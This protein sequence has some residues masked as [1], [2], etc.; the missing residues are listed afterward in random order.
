MRVI[1][2]VIDGLADR[3]AQA[4][5]GMTP[6]EAAATPNLD[7]IV[8]RGSG[9]LHSSLGPGV[10]PG[11]DTA[12]FVFLGNRLQDYPGRALFEAAGAGL[13]VAEGEVVL[14]GSFCHVERR[15]DALHLVNRQID[16]DAD[17]ACELV[18]GIAAHEAGGYR[19][20]LVH[21]VGKESILYVR[22]GSLSSAV[23]DSDPYADDAFV[24][25]V[26]AMADAED[27]AEAASTADAVT[28]YLRWAH[29]RLAAHPINTERIS[30][31]QAP[32]NFLATKWAATRR[33]IVQFSERFPFV[34]ASV[35]WG[36]LFRGLCAE[37][38]L[39]FRN[40]EYL[41]DPGND[42]ARRIDTALELL[43]A[44]R[45][46]FVHVHTKLVDHAAH[47]KDPQLKRQTIESCDAGLAR[48]AV[49]DDPETLIVVT[50]DHATASSGDSL[51]IH[52]GEPV[53]I[54]VV[55]RTVPV[56]EVTRFSE[57]TCRPGMLGTTTA[58][59][60]MPRILNWTDRTGY[61][62]ARMSP[63]SQIARPR[64]A[65]PFTVA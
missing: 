42:L 54:A 53:P 41:D 23:T 2:V 19:L 57:R 38:G 21:T 48:L 44:G 3:P 18:A 8:S 30:A 52:T 22:G 1:F 62:G 63:Y 34:G 31:G 40:V 33:P 59:D 45:Y 12:H 61:Q 25:A 39:A 9:G 10:P 51:L 35:S 58:A 6:L 37:L 14:A 7:A 26:E 24:V 50:A 20:Q 5:G 28:G 60:M 36:T 11:T 16:I 49:L 64:A 13:A 17:D 55:G 56:D 29:E 43:D 47:K 4:L 32:A 65:N 27:P 15:G 46:D